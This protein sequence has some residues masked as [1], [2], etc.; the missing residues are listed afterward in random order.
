MQAKFPK[1]LFFRISCR[2]QVLS[3]NLLIFQ[4]QEPQGQ[5][6]DCPSYFGGFC[7]NI[8]FFLIQQEF[9]LQSGHT[10]ERARNIF[11]SGTE[12]PAYGIGLQ[13]GIP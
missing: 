7:C 12:F 1:A 10:S 2:I 6:T 9:R 3:G 11:Y 13:A 8:V 5:A 4:G